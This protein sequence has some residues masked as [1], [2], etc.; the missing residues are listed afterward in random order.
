MK[1]AALRADLKPVLMSRAMKAGK[2]GARPA[3]G[4]KVVKTKPDRPGAAR[5]SAAAKSPPGRPAAP[6][7]G[8]RKATR[9]SRLKLVDPTLFDPLTEG[10]RAD[11][12]RTF[13]EDRRLAQM[14]KVA[15]YRV[16]AVEPLVVKPPHPLFG[17]RAARVVAYDYATD[18]SVEAA[19]DLD[20]G[21]VVHLAIGTAQPMLS[22]DEEAAAAAIALADE[23]VKRELALGD[24]PLAAMHYWSKRD[25]D[26]AF[27]RRCAAV[28]FGQP[29]ARASWVVVVDLVGGQVVELCPAAQW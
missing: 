14:A 3:K 8:G 6:A 11:A 10:E 29:G 12:L 21:A 28:L 17:R 24:Q 26:P 16:I 25:H 7:P 5:R 18:R 23:R 15:R 27:Q 9:P 22:R 1:R 19:V 4:S 20:A 2:S 13:T